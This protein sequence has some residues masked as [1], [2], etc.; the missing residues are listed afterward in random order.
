MFGFFGVVVSPMNQAIHTSIRT[1]SGLRETG[2]LWGSLLRELGLLSPSRPVPSTVLCGIAVTRLR[3]PDSRGRHRRRKVPFKD[4]VV[5]RPEARSGPSLPL[6]PVVECSI[7]A[8]A[9]E[10]QRRRCRRHL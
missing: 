7:T 4:S 10:A 6:C 3:V 8:W 5:S 2:A 9:A 1:L